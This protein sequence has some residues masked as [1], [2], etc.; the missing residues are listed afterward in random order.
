MI[1]GFV[2]YASAVWVLG[3]RVKKKFLDKW[4]TK[5]QGK[6]NTAASV[7]RISNGGGWWEN[8]KI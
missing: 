5:I 8:V 1:F 2:N 6:V 4:K 3:K 7:V